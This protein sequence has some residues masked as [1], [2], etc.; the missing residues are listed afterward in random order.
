MTAKFLCALPLLLWSTSVMSQE[1]CRQGQDDIFTVEGYEV[2]E[3]DLGYSTGIDL[4]VDLR[5]TGDRGVRMIEGGIIFQDVLGRDI[6]RIAIEPDLK[7]EAGAVTRQSGLYTN[8]RLLEVSNEDVVVTACTK[9]LVYSN[10]EVFKV[11]S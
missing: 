11:G 10:G 3:T 4:K 6:L 5:N 1:A 7:I 8:D 2:S 9:G